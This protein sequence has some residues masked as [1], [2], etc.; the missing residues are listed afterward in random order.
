MAEQQSDSKPLTPAQHGV[1]Q[2]LQATDNL[3]RGISPLQQADPKSLDQWF[4]A[5][6]ANLVA[7]MPEAITDDQLLPVVEALRAKRLTFLVEQAKK[8][9]EP[10]RGRKSPQTL[11]QTIR[12]L[13]SSDIS[14]LED[15]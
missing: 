10:K 7:G 3:D 1:K 4:E 14:D 8:D 2:M 15:L 12:I 13:D 9:S 11:Q 5:V 6:T